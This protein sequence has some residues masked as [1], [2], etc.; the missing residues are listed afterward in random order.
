MIRKWYENIVNDDSSL[1]ERLFRIIMFMGIIAMTFALIFCVIMQEMQILIVLF[2]ISMVSFAFTIW[3][4]YRYH[5]IDL[6][7]TVTWIF[8][9]LILLPVTFFV[10]GGVE[11]GA[12]VWFVL[13][14]VLIFLLFKGKRFF[15]FLAITLIEYIVL[16]YTAYQNEEWIVPMYSRAYVYVDSVMAVFLVG[17]VIGGIMR[18]QILVFTKEREL[19]E[20]RSKEIEQ[21]SQSKSTFFANVSHEIRTPINTIIGLNEM[22]LREDIPDEVAENAIHIQNASKMLLALINDVLDLSKI[23]SGMMEIVPVQYETGAMF[24][25]LVNI[26]WIRAHEKKLDFKVN[27]SENIPSM[28]FGDEVRLKQILVNIL[29]NAVKYTKEGAI[30]LSAD[31]KKIDSNMIQLKVAV[32]DTGMGIHKDS[33][34]DLFS[35]FKRV[36]LEKNRTVEGT[37]LGLSITK[38]LL[39]LMDGKIEVDSI[40]TKGSI[41]TITVNQKIIDETPMGAADFMMRDQVNQRKTYQQSFE[42]PDA[43]IL[44]VDDNEMNRLVIVKLLR[45]TKVQVETAA[46]GKECLAMTRKKYYN[47]IFMDHKMPE[48]DGIET[49]QQIQKQAD[50]FCKSIPVIALTANAMSGAETFYRSYGFQGYLAKPINGAL[51]E[52]CL[53]KY[54]PEELIE[55]SIQEEISPGEKTDGILMGKARAKKPVCITTDCVCDLPKEWIEQYGIKC[56][57]YYVVTDNGKFSDIDEVSSDNLLYYLS[58]EHNHAYS[59]H[60][61]VEE[62]ERFFADAL[63]EAEHIIHISMSKESG[64]GYATAL[65]A[66]RGFDHVTVVDSGHLSSGMGLIVAHAAHMVQ[67]H[68][69]TEEI[70][71]EIEDYKSCVS[72]SFIVPSA[73]SLYRSGKISKKVSRISE[74]LDLHP[75]L[76]LSNGRIRCHALLNGR[77]EHA[78]EKYIYNCL[79]NARRI[80][81][82]ILFVTYAGCDLKQRKKFAETIGKY[83]D[84]EQI[85]FQKASATVTSNCGLGAMGL[86]YVRKR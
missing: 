29:S 46:S 66:A 72:T 21:I 24:S 80:D 44:V 84:F 62:Y 3:C 70:L 14:I 16:Y 55:Y 86:I 8:V 11:S 12:S 7:A 39:D 30:T 73:E 28:L 51:L 60:A 18:F 43:K 45:A 64:D 71:Q 48:M 82:G 41:F 52:S 6:P 2:S 20:K 59:V 19:S 61:S 37:G 79:H 5:K 9:D 40:Y 1:R 53:I 26:I 25:D 58:E 10:S 35:S 27:I 31:C 85:I 63:I 69:N 49:L 57:Y 65:S 67:E 4:S 22:T 76:Q 81:K 32:E 36:D 13:G 50:G 34:K 83:I 54:L 75:V 17:L 56:M 77:I 42:A 74:V 78:Y 15:I 33:M 47:L 23:E 68:H 38:Q